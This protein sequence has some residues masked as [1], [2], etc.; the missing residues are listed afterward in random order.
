MEINAPATLRR[1]FDEVIVCTGS[2]PKTLPVKGFNKTINF[3]QLL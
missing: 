2:A 1:E 3:T